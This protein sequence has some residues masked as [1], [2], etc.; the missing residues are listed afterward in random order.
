MENS[1]IGTLGATPEQEDRALFKT[2]GGPMEVEIVP[3]FQRPKKHLFL[4][5]GFF[6]GNTEIIAVFS[7]RRA[8]ETKPLSQ[9]LKA[10]ENATR[11]RAVAHRL[12]PPNLES[13]RLSVQ[14]KG[15]W[16]YKFYRDA[17]GEEFKVFELLV[18][19]W[20]FT[21]QQ[22][23][24]HQFGEAPAFDVKTRKRNKSYILQSRDVDAV[25]RESRLGNAAE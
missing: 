19:R 24:L 12:P 10:L 18:A 13:I 14:I 22:G 4:A 11:Q 17:D 8:L 23:T 1:S 16:Q 3:H 6:D 15:S 7:G 9:Y 5:K 20:A 2:Y 25:P 21:D